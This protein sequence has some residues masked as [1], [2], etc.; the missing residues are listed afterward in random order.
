MTYLTDTRGQSVGL[1]RFILSLIAGVPII[2]ITAKVTDPILAGSRNATSSAKANDATNWLSQGVDWLPVWFLI[3]AF[4]GVVV[5][6]IY[7]RQLLG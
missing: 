2:W 6:A 4:L 3:V 1:A 5:L 7:Q